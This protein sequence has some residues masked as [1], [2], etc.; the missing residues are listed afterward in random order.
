M[1]PPDA[2]HVARCTI[3]VS[4]RALPGQSYLRS[5]ASAFADNVGSTELPRPQA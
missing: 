3:L 5:F 4:S 2:S 1:S